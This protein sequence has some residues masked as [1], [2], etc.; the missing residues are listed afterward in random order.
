[1][2]KTEV[3]SREKKMRGQRRDETREKREEVG[4]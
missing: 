1:M 2:M 4:G 3:S